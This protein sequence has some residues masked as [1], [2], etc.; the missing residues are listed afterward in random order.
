MRL[1]LSSST[2][3]SVI[4]DGE[5]WALFFNSESPSSS[6][7]EFCDLGSLLPSLL[8]LSSQARGAGLLFSLIGMVLLEP[9]YSMGFLL[10]GDLGNSIYLIVSGSAATGFRVVSV[11]RFSW[12]PRI[13]FTFRF[14]GMLHKLGKTVTFRIHNENEHWA[15]LSCVILEKLLNFSEVRL[16]TNLTEPWLKARDGISFTYSV[17]SMLFGS[18]TRDALLLNNI[19]TVGFLW[20]LEILCPYAQHS[21]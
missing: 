3:L 21:D 15:L 2:Y 10:R 1:L 17:F 20:D 12:V 19:H 16:D 13:S 4:R 5:G 14:W 18:F 8:G 7:E 9:T 6:E 11:Y